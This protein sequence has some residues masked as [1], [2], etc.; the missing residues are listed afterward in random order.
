[1][2]G[3][4][5]TTSTMKTITF[6]MIMSAVTIGNCNG[7]LSLSPNGIKIMWHPRTRSRMNILD[8]VELLEFDN[9]MSLYYHSAIFAI[10]V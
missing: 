4:P 10:Q 2:N 1:M 3:W 6:A 5:S 8:L 7:L 9:E